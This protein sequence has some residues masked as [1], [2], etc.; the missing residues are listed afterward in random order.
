[1]EI[2]V[3]YEGELSE[4]SRRHSHFAMLHNAKITKSEKRRW[5]RNGG[6]SLSHDI[7]IVF[8]GKSGYGKSSTVN[9][10]FGQSIMGTSDVQACTR[11]IQSFEFKIKDGHFFSFADLPGIGESKYRD[12]EY[13]ALYAKIIKKADAIIYLIRADSRDFAIDEIAFKHLFSTPGV[14]GRVILA[15]NCCDKIE[16][17]NRRLPFTPTTEQ[18]QNIQQKIKSVRKIF[19]PQNKVVPYS[20]TTEWNLTALA[21]EMLRVVL[22]SNDITLLNSTHYCFDS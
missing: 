17:V 10:F 2:S 12:E 14:S 16:P 11:E 1:M 7:Q 22:L 8:I 13:L 20:A 19:N 5:S 6:S 9:A 21:E 3:K 15:L 18:H 4:L